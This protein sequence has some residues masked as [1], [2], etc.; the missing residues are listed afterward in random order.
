MLSL[1]GASLPRHLYPPGIGNETGL[2]EPEAAVR[3]HDRILDVAGTSVSDIYG[4]SESWFGT[5]AADAFADQMKDLIRS[6]F[7]DE[8]LFVFKDPRTALVFPLWRR[9]LAQANIGCLPVI[10][11]RNPVEVALSLAERQAKAVPGQSWPLE[12]GGLLWLRYTLAA[13]RF[14]RDMPRSFCLYADLLEDWRKVARRLAFDFDL[15]WPRPLSEAGR[16]IDSFLSAQLRH[17]YQSGEIGIRGAIWSS[18]IAPVFATLRDAS[19]GLAPDRA[20]LDAV[21]RSFENASTGVRSAVP[22]VNSKERLADLAV[23]AAHDRIPGQKRLCLVGTASLMSRGREEQ[24]RRIVESATNAGFDV[25][26]VCV[27]ALPEPAGAALE[28]LVAGYR[29]DIQHCEP[30]APPIEPAYMRSTI[31]LFRH[32][33]ARRF[34]AILFQ[35][36]EGLAYASMIAK[37][38][39]LAFAETVLGVLAFGGTRWRRE[40]NHRF[41]AG[42]VTIA[43]EFIERRAVELADVVILASQQS[44]LWMQE[45]GWRLG[46]TLPLPEAAGEIPPADAIWTPMLRLL[47]PA[48]HPPTV[49]G[50]EET[51]PADITVVIAHFEQPNLLDQ[52]LSAL[53]QQT[54][55]NFSVLVVDDGSRSEDAS[56]YLAG[57]EERYRALD[58]RLIRQDNRFL[59][60]ARNAGIRAANTEF[61]ILL[62]DD[63]VAFPDMVRTLRRAIQLAQADVVTC[64]IS[65]F[66]DATGRPRFGMDRGGPDQFFA[67]GPIL[68]GAIHNCFGDASGIYRKAIFDKVGYFYELHGVTFEDWQMHLKIVTAGFRLLSLPEP[69]VWYRIRP[70]SMLRRTQRYDNACVIAATINEMPCSILEPLA[71]YLMGS[72]EEQVS[73]NGEIQAIRAVAAA[74]SVALFE[75]KTEALR[76][77]HDLEE[78]LEERTKS[79]KKAE[80]YA[81]SLEASLAEHRGS[82]KAAQEI[83]E[84]RTKTAKKAEEFAR[85]REASLAE[86]R[87]SL[88]VAQEILDERTKSVTNAEQY[89]H[90]L[91]ASLADHRR[92]LKAMQ[93]TLDER[94]NS[95]KKAEAFARSLEASLAEHQGSLKVAQEILEERTKSAINAEQYAHSL[96]ASLDEHRRSLEAAR[97]V[98]EERTKSATNAEQYA[99]SLETSLAEL[100]ESLKA[101]TEYAISLERS[102]AEMEAYAKSLETELGKPVEDR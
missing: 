5:R 67:A 87:G 28:A 84:E 20:V 73:L 4:P 48:D 33:R 30:S 9:V 59:G 61:V 72:E 69:L 43:T 2:W 45:A 41:P 44:A 100:R 15:S 40:R 50:C 74:N 62:D 42:L 70:D 91:E 54:D 49:S 98:I 36:D 102:R 11:S 65:H 6:E 32:L 58:L 52:N 12:R 38:T 1:L 88:K 53:T 90:S 92:S 77:A 56:L 46:T 19:T 55:S 57:I 80:E 21:G 37:Q 85:S 13:E 96:E 76:H 89:A 27:G 17:H 93:E 82:L 101:S 24:L 75:A 66:D 23:A 64:G 39:G 3:L 7:G 35:D 83:L 63:N 10:I 97:E 16:D 31:D 86:H 22:P 81:R 34:D 60:A 99:R 79:A 26:I 29:A 71:D 95:A 94:T 8:R 78:I 68:L 18:W 51:R 25:T 47:R 14:T